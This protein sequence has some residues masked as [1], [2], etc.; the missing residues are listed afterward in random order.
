MRFLAAK[1]FF[2]FLKPLLSMIA[3]HLI[4]DSAAENDQFRDNEKLLSTAPQTS[5][6]LLGFQFV[7]HCVPKDV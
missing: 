7:L 6:K 4:N 2:F 1:V 3:P 5:S